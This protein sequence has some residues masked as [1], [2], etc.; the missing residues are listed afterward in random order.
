MV[1]IIWGDEPGTGPEVDIPLGA[2]RRNI[3][4]V[5]GTTLTVIGLVSTYLFQQISK[6]DNNLRQRGRYLVTLQGYF[7]TFWFAIIYAFQAYKY[8]FPCAVLYWGSYLTL[9]PFVLFVLGRSWRL[10][11]RFHRNNAIYHA[12]FIEPSDLTVLGRRGSV[13]GP[14]VSREQQHNGNNSINTG[15]SNS[16]S[17]EKLFELS[18][19]TLEEI[20]QSKKWYN[21]YRTVTDRQIF[22]FGAGYMAMTTS[23][24]IYYQFRSPNISINPLS[25]NCHSGDEY[26]LPYSTM[27]SFLFV[28]GPFIIT[29]LK[30]VKDGFGIR[31]ELIFTSLF[32][33]PCVALYFVMP[34][35]FPNFTRRVLDRTTWMAL[36]LIASHLTSTLIPLVQHFRTYPHQC[37]YTARA[38]Q[39]KA[40]RKTTPGTF[41]TT[42]TEATEDQPYDSESKAIARNIAGGAPG[43]RPEVIPLYATSQ[44]TGLDNH[45]Q[46]RPFPSTTAVPK[47]SD[48]VQG[49]VD[50]SFLDDSHRNNS[51]NNVNSTLKGLTRNQKRER[52]GLGLSLRMNNSQGTKVENK[53]TDWD[54]FIRTL[55]DRTLFNRMSAFTVREFCAEN[56]RFLY[57]VS[58]L[59]KRALQYEHL[60]DLTSSSSSHD[61]LQ[62]TA[63][64]ASSPSVAETTTDVSSTLPASDKITKSS[65]VGTRNSVISPLPTHFSNTG[66]GS[67]SSHQGPHRI[68]KIVSASSVSSTMPILVRRSSSSYFDDSEP[69]SPSGTSFRQHGS[70][71]SSTALP[72]LEGGV[73]AQTDYLN[74][75][76]HQDNTIQTA[77]TTP[78]PSST[79]ASTIIN[80]G[81]SSP[82]EHDS[83][84][85]TTKRSF[86]PLP[87][88][89][90]LLIHFE[91]V[92]KTFIVSG[93]RLE[94]NLSHKTLQ[95]IHQMA[96]RGEWRSGMFDGAIYEIQELLFRDVWP[97]F[98]TSSQGLNYSGSSPDTATPANRT[99]SSVST[100]DRAHLQEAIFPSGSGPSSTHGS[101]HDNTALFVP[102]DQQ[103]RQQQQRQQQRQQS[104]SSLQ[105]KATIP[106]PPSIMLTSQ[107]SPLSRGASSSDTGAGSANE[108]IIQMSAGNSGSVGGGG[109]YYNGG[110]Y[111]YNNGSGS[112]VSFNIQGAPHHYNHQGRTAAS[113]SASAEDTFPE[114]VSRSGPGLKSW[115]TK[116]SRTGMALTSNNTEEE[117]LGI[118]EQSRK[119]MM[120]R[121]SGNSDLYSSSLQNASVLK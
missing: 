66:N 104:S 81:P 34:A 15:T 88:P 86:A 46:Q 68:K 73:G 19:H 92:Y 51:G 48:L 94:L 53:K 118:I 58:R 20:E 44:S 54:E 67:A 49:A 17:N 72:G 56:T 33:I 43:F 117:S 113:A 30:D 114:G 69:S 85:T 28:L 103:Q 111:N 45:Q 7:G 59:E 5:F 27:I 57:E 55:E 8:R 77:S 95:E 76:Y 87:M 32:S 31:K 78:A 14:A 35:L 9:V 25:Y 3:L 105:R 1:E 75:H 13:N 115:F 119:S 91:Y 83:A 96:R 79:A 116:K 64:T 120:D 102:F 11:T 108:A 22:Y 121:R 4:I 112:A 21:R 2:L 62:Q 60:R 37:Q 80:M 42:A 16:N 98:V 6:K 97:K 40:Q 65:S 52:F 84:P 10:I 93:A 107:K 63:A 74:H 82:Q 39:R 71:N 26:L 90:T 109:G 29:R 101:S 41:S 12:R 36:I 106:E 99:D 89:P 100:R 61:L 50:E 38:F 23:V 110:Y 70:N 24:A 18:H 47:Y